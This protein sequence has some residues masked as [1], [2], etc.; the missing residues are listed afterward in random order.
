MSADP[1]TSSEGSRTLLIRDA[2]YIWCG[3]DI[4]RELADAS[5]LCVDGVIA[6]VGRPTAEWPPADETIDASDCVVL[7][8][9]VNT[10]HHLYQTLTRAFSPALGCDLFE[11]LT[12]LYPVWAR[13][14]EESAYLSAWVGLAE[15]LLSGCTTS[16]DLLDVHPHGRAGLIDAEIKAAGELG[17][18]FHATRGSMSL[19]Q[20]DGGLPP[21]EVVE[22]EDRIL[23]DSER[24]VKT[25]H[26]PGPGAMV[27]V[28]LAPCSPFSV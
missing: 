8:G 25:F 15:L 19:S 1:M 23:A 10:H 14:D 2:A 24:V 13:L 22:D 6:R 18:R 27:R 20:K 16:S 9:L 26:D 12:T 17:I 7:P 21:D 11:W 3:D 28:G 5:I 4:G